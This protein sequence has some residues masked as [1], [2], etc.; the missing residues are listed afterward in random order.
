VNNKDVY[1]PT[2]FDMSLA[3]EEWMWKNM[4]PRVWKEIWHKEAKEYPQ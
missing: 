4:I 3:A 1:D 2:F